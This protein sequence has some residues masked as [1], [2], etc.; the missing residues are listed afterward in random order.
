M[1][2]TDANARQHGNHKF[3]YHRHVDGHA[4]AFLNSELLQHV[5]KL[6]HL[7]GGVGRKEEMQALDNT[8]WLVAIGI[9]V[10]NDD[11][12]LLISLRGKLK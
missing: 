4:V 10:N 6:A 11:E 1:H 5:R 9:T 2:G 8:M 3:Q 7:Y 12:E